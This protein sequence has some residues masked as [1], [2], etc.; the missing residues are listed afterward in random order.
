MSKQIAAAI[1]LLFLVLITACEADDVYNDRQEEIMQAIEAQLKSF[2]IDDYK[3]FK[4]TNKRAAGEA[5]NPHSFE[6]TYS[7]TGKD[8][9]PFKGKVSIDHDDP[10]NGEIKAAHIVDDYAKTY[11]YEQIHL[12]DIKDVLLS[13]FDEDEINTIST[14]TYHDFIEAADLHPSLTYQEVEKMV[15][16]WFDMTKHIAQ[17]THIYLKVDQLSKEEF[18][19]IVDELKDALPFGDYGLTIEVDSVWEEWE[20]EIYVTE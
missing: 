1:P 11:F 18:H 2:G 10:E 16:N 9:V 14:Y 20:A 7:Y 15:D 17:Q 6:F 3:E 12:G 8:A 13:H 5:L 19:A 4:V